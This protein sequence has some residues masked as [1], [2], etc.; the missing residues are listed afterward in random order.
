MSAYR[1]SLWLPLDTY[2]QRQPLHIA[3][4]VTVKVTVQQ[5]VYFN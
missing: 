3:R 2:A 4:L 5:L 1:V